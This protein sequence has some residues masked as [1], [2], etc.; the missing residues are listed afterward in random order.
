MSNTWKQWEGQIVGGKFP[1]LL[2]LGSS[3]YGAVFLT[4]RH[5]GDNLAKAAI[6]LVPASSENGELNLSSWRQAAELSHPHLIPLYEMGRCE[7]GGELLIFVLMEYAE[8]N[9]A[10]VLPERA[11]TPDEAREMLE[12]VLDA[13]A[14]LHRNGFVHGHIKPANIMA[15]A[16]KLKVSCDGLC[17]VGE[18]S[19]VLGTL[20]AYDAPEYAPSVLPISEAISTQGDVWSLGMTLVETLTQNLPDLRTADQQ[21]PLFPGTL[22]EPFLEIATH[23]L[24]R[25][26]KGRWTVAQI[27]ARLMGRAPVSAAPESHMPQALMPQPV[28]QPAKRVAKRSGYPAPI[29]IGIAL[30]IAAILLGPRLLRRH[31]DAQEV[32]AATAAAQP[33][34]QSAPAQAAGAQAASAPQARASDA[35]R[36]NF[37]EQDRGSKAPVPQPALIHPDS[38]HAEET[39]TAARFPVGSPVRGEVAHKAMPEVLQSARNTIRGTVRVR[40]K[41]NVDRSGNVEDAELQSS[42]P[43][44]YFARA[45][46]E[47]AKNW[48]FKPA[49]VG[50]RGVLS[51]WT[52]QFDF[53]RDE[54]TVT[55]TQEMP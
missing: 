10:Q 39:D 49:T 9:L 23:C 52:L 32:P 21:D 43:S 46:L 27:E 4:E 38:M 44:K 12:S 45:A 40:V 16:D 13:L 15:S 31:T 35:D 55:P 51:T 48:E 8:E 30:A 3:G 28:A 25:H 17:R 22:P 50:G 2:Y 41:V 11:L 20:D 42:G 5:E 36:P 37:A 53:T 26:P 19:D 34:V 18:S 6:K 14:Y 33:P 54:T 24:V 47:A 29:A 7:L 1:L